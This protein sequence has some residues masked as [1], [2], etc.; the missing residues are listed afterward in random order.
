MGAG[1]KRVAIALLERASSQDIVRLQSFLAADSHEAHRAI[2]SREIAGDFY[3]FPGL[4]MPWQAVPPG[5]DFRIPHDCLSGLMVRPDNAG[6]LLIDPGEAGFFVPVFSGSTADDSD[7]VVVQSAGV[8]ALGVLTFTANAGPGVRWDIVECQPTETVLETSLRDIFDEPTQQF[9]S[10]SVTKVAGGTLTFRI[11]SGTA[12][13]GI[14]NPD[15]EWMPLAAIHVRT[16]ATGFANCDVYDIRP[17]VNERCP[18]SPG[19]YRGAPAAGS[20]YPGYRLHMNEAS[21]T[22]A[23]TTAGITGKALGGYFRSQWGGYWSGG[24]IRRN[25]PSGALATFGGTAANEGSL[26]FFNPQATE[27]RSSGYSIA[28]DDRFT[29]GAFFPRGY[30]RW[31]RYSQ[32]ALSG[33]AS[34]RLRRAG[35]LPQGPRGVLWITKGTVF[36]NGVIPGDAPPTA[37]GDTENAFGHAVVE[38]LTEG[39]SEFYPCVGGTNA[40]K[41]SYPRFIVTT[42]SGPT[43][44]SIVSASSVW[45][46][47]GALTATA[48][49]L[50]SVDFLFARAYPVPPYARAVQLEITIQLALA[51]VATE[52]TFRG[53]A[54]VFASGV[55]RGIKPE[56]QMAHTFGRN[57]DDI[58]EFRGVCWVPLWENPAFDDTNISGPGI[59]QLALT[60]VH[61]S[62]TPTLGV[63][64]ASVVGYQL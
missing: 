11:R 41:F 60:F 6:D 51:P 47:A 16:D 54:V 32:T 61:S 22:F 39:T 1:N 57:S 23:P 5:A 10:V 27:N 21:F 15:P 58:A 40:R 30:P 42:A 53:A 56:I 46:I 24:A 52:L 17:L 44:T 43:P 3:N 26:A 14:P 62:G 45:D 36:A 37:F 29:V 2:Q 12:G 63:A 33:S 48:G 25:T 35:R 20:S 8:Q 34:N 64:Q 7:Y 28:G 18:W 59:H 49:G 31:V 13:G 4:Q 50:T 9:N 19:D 55:S 38:G